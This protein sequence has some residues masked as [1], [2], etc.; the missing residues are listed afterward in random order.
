M[1]EFSGVGRERAFKKDAL[2]AVV[3]P[4]QLL[5]LPPSPP[6]TTHNSAMVT[7]IVVPDG[8]V[9]PASRRGAHALTAC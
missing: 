2:H 8:C 3:T 1:T 6:P 4:N 5:L 7:T 9:P